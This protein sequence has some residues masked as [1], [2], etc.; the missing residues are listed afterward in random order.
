MSY[1][2][3][4]LSQLLKIM[5]GTGEVRAAQFIE[6]LNAAMHE[7]GIDTPKRQAAFLAQIGHESCGLRYVREIADGSAYNGRVALGNTRP[8][9]IS[10]ASRNDTSPG[11]FFKGRGLIQITGFDN[12]RACSR[13]LF[14]DDN[15]LTHNPSLLER[16]DLACRSAAW[17]WDSRSLNSFADAGDFETITRKI[18]GGLNGQADRLAYYARA[19]QA[20]AEPSGGGADASG[21]FPQQN[22]QQQKAPSWL[23]S[24]QQQFRRLFN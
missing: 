18:N 8:E 20:L 9:A 11:P 4:T 6:P 15:T 16:F 23:R 5:A 12:Y 24:L 10:I 1:N 21:P 3:I 2:E 7:F 19:Q 17:F 14:N 22:N 13:A